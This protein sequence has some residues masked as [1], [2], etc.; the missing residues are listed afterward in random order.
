[1]RTISRV[2]EN[3]ERR[4]GGEWKNGQPGESQYLMNRRRTIPAQNHTSKLERDN[5]PSV[6]RLPKLQVRN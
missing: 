4:F 2:A 1:M 3:S 6:R 5:G